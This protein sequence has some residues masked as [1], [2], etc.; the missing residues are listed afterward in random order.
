[1]ELS[2]CPIFVDAEQCRSRINVFIYGFVASPKYKLITVCRNQ[3]D[4]FS[5]EQGAEENAIIVM[6]EH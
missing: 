4:I 5:W 6:P 2:P 3:C 1:M